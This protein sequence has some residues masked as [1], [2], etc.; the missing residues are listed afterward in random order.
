MFRLRPLHL[1]EKIL[2]KKLVLIRQQA[3]SRV[4]RFHTRNMYFTLRTAIMAYEQY[5]N[6][7]MGMQFVRLPLHPTPSITPDILVAFFIK[8]GCI[9]DCGKE[10]LSF[11]LHQTITPETSVIPLNIKCNY[12]TGF[13][14]HILCAKYRFC[15]LKKQL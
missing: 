3:L 1:T 6:R 9:S 13:T 15:G 5:Q 4:S 8:T 11:G 7:L 10:R 2:K 12:I 14:V